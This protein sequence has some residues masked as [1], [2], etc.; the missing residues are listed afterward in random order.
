[1]RWIIERC[2]QFQRCNDLWEYL[3]KLT[4][5]LCKMNWECELGSEDRKQPCS[6][7]TRGLRVWSWTQPPSAS[8]LIQASWE[9]MCSALCCQVIQSLNHDLQ[10]KSPIV[11]SNKSFSEAFVKGNRIFMQVLGNPRTP[12]KQEMAL[13]WSQVKSLSLCVCG[14]VQESILR[15]EYFQC[16]ET[17][18]EKP[19]TISLSGAQRLFLSLI[20]QGIVHRAKKK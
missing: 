13:K 6:L 18:S 17:F 16:K 12:W 5:W 14:S 8:Y 9:I 19:W 11:L 10:I 4:W 15:A 2:R 7:D 20:S 3:K 1:M